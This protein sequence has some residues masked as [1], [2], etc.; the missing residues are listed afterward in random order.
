MLLNSHTYFSYKFGT[1]SIEKLIEE[2][3]EKNYKAIVLS[4]INSTSACLDFVRLCT[5]DNIR[6]ILG[7]DFRNG[8]KQQYIGIAMNNMGFQELNEHLS[9]HL[10]EDKDFD[11]K[12]PEFINAYVVYPFGDID[13][14][15]L[16]TNEYIGI[17]PSQLTKIRLSEWKNYQDKLV[18]LQSVTFQ[19]KR[20]FN[21]HR[22]FR[23]MDNN[24]LLSRLAK[25]EEASPDEI[26]LQEEEILRLYREYPLLIENTERIIDTC[27]I[28]FEF[29]SFK[30]N[31]PL[32]ILPKMT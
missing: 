25:T 6:P 29:K 3:K 17:K 20:D 19:N 4:D 11:R 16:K 1:L 30:T 15:E 7:I 27:S 31:K 12:A 13:Y 24:T 22:L 14:H 10:H 32:P 26:M 9:K 18:I 23:A 8:A 28:H 5:K 21:I 2:A